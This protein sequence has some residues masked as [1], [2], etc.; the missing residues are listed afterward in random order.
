MDHNSW[1]LIDSALFL[2]SAAQAYTFLKVND[3]M[4][5]G[6]SL[7]DEAVESWDKHHFGLPTLATVINCRM[8]RKLCQTLWRRPELRRTGLQSCP[9]WLN[10]FTWCE[11]TSDE[12]I[13]HGTDSGKREG[14]AGLRRLKDE[15]FSRRT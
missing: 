5:I 13:L 3:D 7:F 12:A 15:D 11:S 9:N 8:D 2:I 1:K 10:L 6:K 14:C 4:Q